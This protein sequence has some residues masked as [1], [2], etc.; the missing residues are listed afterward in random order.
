MDKTT[1]T[2][3]TTLFWKRY[4]SLAMFATS[5]VLRAC[6]SVVVV[7]FIA[8]TSSREVF[9]DF[10]CAMMTSQLFLPL[11]ELGVTTILVREFSREQGNAGDWLSMAILVKVLLAVF[12][13]PASYYLSVAID[14]G[15]TIPIM[16]AA[17]ST[18]YLFRVP[19]P[20]E[21]WAIS[22]HR[23]DLPVIAR[24][25]S[26]LAMLLA[27]W[28]AA[29]FH[30]PIIASILAYSSSFLVHS[31]VIILLTSRCCK[32]PCL[33]RKISF[34]KASIFIGQ[35]APLFIAAVANN[36]FIRIGNLML[37]S[38]A[39]TQ[40]AAAYIAASRLSQMF[41]LIP[42][43]LAD[44]AFPK[45]VRLPI[46]SDHSR[47]AWQYLMNIQL[48]LSLA[49]VTAAT[50]AAPYLIPL[51]FGDEYSDAVGVFRLH[52]LSLVFVATSVNC[53][54]SLAAK[55]LQVYTLAAGLLGLT[56]NVA[57]NLVLI[58]A[59]SAH[60]AA[61]AYTLSYFLL[62]FAIYAAFPKTYYLV[63]MQLL[64]V[65]AIAHLKLKPSALK[66]ISPENDMGAALNTSHPNS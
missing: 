59:Y 25:S 1:L 44:V 57:L 62:S 41:S 24:T 50:A 46:D 40:A 11:F 28:A 52:C 58:P 56:A 63:R 19:E 45:L 5:Q 20:Y 61:L 22:Q 66:S 17:F 15:T 12:C 30:L 35:S 47:L 3:H 60:G 34:V 36:L 39:G 9:G 10:G 6:Q 51:L 55:H 21:T 23:F 64:S 43:V 49:I 8:R 16:T 32:P 54:R 38:M 7:M 2:H 53:S 42:F 18:S 26:F 14:G 37:Y 65:S 48:A 27:M 4:S 33:R 29:Y 13:I 31:A